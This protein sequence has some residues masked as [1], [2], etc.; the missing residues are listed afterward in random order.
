M[1]LVKSHCML[2]NSSESLYLSQKCNLG[3]LTELNHRCFIWT[4]ECAR[5]LEEC[6]MCTVTNHLK[7]KVVL[8]IFHFVQIGLCMHINQ[9][10]SLIYYC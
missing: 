10:T 5:I 2:Q 6:H 1:L 8:K 4:L 3:P 9:G 7:T